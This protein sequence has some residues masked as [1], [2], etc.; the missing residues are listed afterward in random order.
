MSAFPTA[1]VDFL[2]TAAAGKAVPTDVFQK[3]LDEIVALETAMVSGRARC[4]AYHNATQ[5]LTNNTITLL[6]LN[7]EDFDVGTM[8]DTVTNNTRVTI[9]AGNT[10]IYLVIGGTSFAANATGFRLIQLF[11]N[12]NGGLPLTGTILSATS[13]TDRLVFQVTTVQSLAAGDYIELVAS[14]TSG[15][16]LN[17]GSAT[18]TDASTLQVVRLW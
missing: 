18:R 3:I 10:G 9:P 15:G 16:A 7:S 4:S 11:K 14:Q 1:I 13:G 8:H 12:G 17:V 5:S 6:N 2:Y